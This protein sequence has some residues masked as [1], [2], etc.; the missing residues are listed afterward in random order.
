MAAPTSGAQQQPWSLCAQPQCTMVCIKRV[1][2]LRP[3]ARTLTTPEP[4]V[5]PAKH[6]R[7]WCVRRGISE[8]QTRSD[9]HKVRV[10]NYD[11]FRLSFGLEGPPLNADF[12]G[13]E[14][15]CTVCRL[16]TWCSSALR[17][18]SSPLCRLTC[19]LGIAR[20]G[21]SQNLQTR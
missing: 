10:A 7:S 2:K 19:S 6:T 17:A 21:I 3:C 5:N 9:G 15:V 14:M 8:S 20:R 4:A 12:D 11:T 18:W 13:D 16:W 1:T